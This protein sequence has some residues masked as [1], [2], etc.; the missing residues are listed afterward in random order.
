[1][2]ALGRGRSARLALTALSAHGD[3]HARVHA[4]AHRAE[5]T[6]VD[7]VR[8]GG[9]KGADLMAVVAGEVDTAPQLGK[10]TR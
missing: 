8:S 9:E 4:I 1:M 7:G 5:Q 3:A 2:C 6:I 10:H